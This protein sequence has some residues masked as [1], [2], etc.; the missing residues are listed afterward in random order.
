MMPVTASNSTVMRAFLSE[1]TPV[2]LRDQRPLLV[3]AI[4]SS[5]STDSPIVTPSVIWSAQA[6]LVTFTG[7][8]STADHI[9]GRGLVFA[10]AV[11]IPCPVRSFTGFDPVHSCTGS[12]SLLELSLRD[13]RSLPV[14]AIF[15]SLS[16]G[17]PIITSP[18]FSAQRRPTL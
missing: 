9:S 15:T 17:S 3:E 10:G 2:S 11:S 4:S 7:A 16:T 13:R 8:V 5:L 1:M 12:L 18:Q 6:D 14:E